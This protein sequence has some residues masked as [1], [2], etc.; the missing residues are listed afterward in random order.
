MS[1]KEARVLGA[2]QSIEIDGTEYQIRPINIRMLHEV[3]REAVRHYKREYLK[4]FSDNM[5][6]LGNGKGQELLEQQIKEVAKW[7]IAQLPSKTA[8]SSKGIPIEGKLAERLRVI[9]GDLPTNEDELQG[10]LDSALDR[11]E[12]TSDEVEQLSGKRPKRGRIG[13]DMW[14]ITA[15]YEGMTTFVW[16]SLLSAHPKLQKEQVSGWPLT[17]LT[18]AARIAESITSPELGNT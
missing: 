4:T 16:A 9:Y 10:L 6:L 12:M 3:Q 5:D 1:D 11:E 7:D 17:Q 14:W 13:Y 8:Y 15:T 18:Q 2:G